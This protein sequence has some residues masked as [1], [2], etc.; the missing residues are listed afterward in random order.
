MGGDFYGGKWNNFGINDE[1][2]RRAMH[3]QRVAQPKN[4]TSGN[5]QRPDRI[6]TPFPCLD[7][8]LKLRLGPWAEIGHRLKAVRPCQRDRQC[9]AKLKPRNGQPTFV[10]HLQIY[11]ASSTEKSMSIEVTF[12]VHLPQ[13]PAT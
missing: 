4:I 1:C 2:L 7:E 3:L 12:G 6:I 13:G 5:G 10:L 11:F 9:L 8:I